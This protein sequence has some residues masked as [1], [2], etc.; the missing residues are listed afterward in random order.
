MHMPCTL[1]SPLRCLPSTMSNV[2][3]TVARNLHRSV[4]QMGI[5]KD[6]LTNELQ[7]NVK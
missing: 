4:K 7:Q 2:T 1:H 6:T 3:R 5:R